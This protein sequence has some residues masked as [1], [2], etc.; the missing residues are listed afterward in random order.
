MNVSSVKTIRVLPHQSIVIEVK[1]QPSDGPVL[2]EHDCALEESIG[3]QLEDTLVFPSKEGFVYA[4]ISNLAGCSRSVDAGTIIGRAVEVE[5]IKGSELEPMTESDEE[6][7]TVRSVESVTDRKKKLLGLIDRPTLLNEKQTQELLDFIS[8]HHAAFSLDDLERGE[9][10]LLDMEIY[11]G[12]ETPRR[13]ATRRMPFAVRQEVARQLNNMQG[14]GVIEPSSSPWSSPVVMV[15]KKD[16]T[17]RFCV[18]YRELNKITKRDTFPLPR[19][20][21]LLDQLGNSRYFTT[22]DLASGYWQIR[23]APGSRE[24]TAFITPYG[25][26]Q[27]RVIPFG[28]TNAPAVFKRL[29]QTVLMGLNPVGGKQFVSVYSVHT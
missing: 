3:L 4:I 12:E 17:L 19:V 22:L 8:D 21:D 1:T 27:F 24:K 16:G 20:D 7:P 15:R 14:T 5:V 11:T 28:L 25:L 9:T 29:M 10:N 13:A 23:V 6:L 2:L 18:D 26:F